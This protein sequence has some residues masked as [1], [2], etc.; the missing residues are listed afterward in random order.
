MLYITLL[1][2][3]GSIG[4]GIDMFHTQDAFVNNRNYPGGPVQFQI[5]KFYPYNTAASAVYTMGSWF[6]MGFLVRLSCATKK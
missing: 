4:N 1:F 2:I 6:T 5:E 3:L